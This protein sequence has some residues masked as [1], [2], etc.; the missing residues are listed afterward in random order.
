MSII[1]QPL[2]KWLISSNNQDVCGWSS[3]AL[4]FIVP[5]G[6]EWPNVWLCHRVPPSSE[7]PSPVLTRWFFFPFCN[8]FVWFYGIEHKGNP[9]ICPKLLQIFSGSEEKGESTFEQ[10]NFHF[11]VT[12]LTTD[13]YLCNAWHKRASSF[14]LIP[15]APTPSTYYLEP[16]AKGY[17][18]W[19]GQQILYI[20]ECDSGG[21]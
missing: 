16:C 15:P 12:S 21:Q 6:R 7:W 11:V 17:F 14:S 13:W 4:G 9:W 3:C 20:L 19:P 10:R 1:L 8:V 5:D 18:F 2:W